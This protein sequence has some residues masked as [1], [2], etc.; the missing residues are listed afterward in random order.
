MQS[1]TREFDILWIDLAHIV[2]SVCTC[3]ILRVTT[4]YP[5]DHGCLEVGCLPLSTALQGSVLWHNFVFHFLV[6]VHCGL[7]RYHCGVLKF[8]STGSI[9]IDS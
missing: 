5:L 8:A 2:L 3:T 9:L 7:A 4:L 6:H 1:S